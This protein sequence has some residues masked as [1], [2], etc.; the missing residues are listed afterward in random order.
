MAALK[1]WP[2][3]VELG[4]RLSEE[5]SQ[6]EPPELLSLWI[7]QRL[8]ELIERGEKEKST[9]KREAAR[10]ACADLVVKAWHIRC[11]SRVLE[12]L[13]KGLFPA[14]GT[15]VEEYT[16]VQKVPDNFLEALVLL[17]KVASH[18]HD[19]CVA[20]MLAEAVPDSVLSL[21]EEGELTL[22]KKEQ[23]KYLLERRE[24]LFRALSKSLHPL[25]RVDFSS[26]ESSRNTTRELLVRLQLERQKLLSALEE[27]GA[28][29]RAEKERP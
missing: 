14:T 20:G 5:L 11:L 22:D 15:S 12:I 17:K 7:G 9:K 19:V 4:R 18:E 8:A 6:R 26:L 29:G 24:E 25:C 13:R 16:R 27:V 10:L 3:V 1:D 28:R 2:D 21:W 23:L